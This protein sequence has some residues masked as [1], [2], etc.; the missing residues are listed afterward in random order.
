M[1]AESFNRML[2]RSLEV[3][4]VTLSDRDEFGDQAETIVWADAYGAWAPS[5][6]A[7]TTGDDTSTNTTLD[8][9]LR[10]GTTIDEAS[11][12]RLPAAAGVHAG[13]WQ[14]VGIPG[15]WVVGMAL[16]IRRVT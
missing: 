10:A 14:V 12:V 13:I 2:S 4:T 15:D 6:A 1:R 16:K 7:D 9:F 8:L 3:G 11:K 5:T